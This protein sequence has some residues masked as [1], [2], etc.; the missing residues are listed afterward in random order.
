MKQISMKPLAWFKLA[1]QAR[2][3]FDPEELQRLGESLRQK[4][5]QP[6]VA[7]PEKMWLRRVLPKAGVH[8]PGAI[9]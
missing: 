4:Q 2:R 7:K 5:I 9:G 8:G 6:L 1:S 3:Y